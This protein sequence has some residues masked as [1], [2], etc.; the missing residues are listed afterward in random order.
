[1]MRPR[2]TTASL[3][4]RNEDLQAALRQVRS[5]RDVVLQERND[6]SRRLSE[7]EGTAAVRCVRRLWRLVDRLFPPRSHR[8]AVYLLLRWLLGLALPPF[9]GPRR[10][11]AAGRPSAG[12]GEEVQDARADLLAFEERVRDAGSDEVVVILSATKL[13]E[14]EGQRPT[15]LAVE[16]ARREVPV[17]FLYWRWWPDDWSPQD[18]LEQG[19]VQVPIDVVLDRPEALTEAFAGRRRT[20]LFA[21][22]Y[23]GFFDLVAAAHAEGWLTVYDVLDDWQEFHRVG[24]AVWYEAAFER[25][26]LCS[27]DAVFAVNQ[28]LARRIGEHGRTDPLVVG[29]GFRPGLEVVRRPRLLRRGP[30]TIGYFGHLAAAWFD[31]R[32]VVEAARR[33]PSWRFYL[34]GYGSPADL[35][36]P[37]NVG[38]LGK[39][40]QHELAA[41][42]AN[43]DV[44]IVPFKTD[45]LAAGADPIKTYEYLAIGLPVVVT[46]VSAPS[47][48]ERFVTRADGIDGFVAALEHAAIDPDRDA[49]A[50]RAFAASCTWGHRL[51]AMLAAV[52]RGDQRAAEKRALFG[53]LR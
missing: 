48:G 12:G 44:A 23:P 38:L 7:L 20:I 28:V 1:M 3:R 13:L 31:W 2:P 22:P 32:L 10:D 9:R 39:Q 5:Q 8:R 41:Y 21:F 46:G 16:W 11:A 17:V 43:W 53:G 50:R 6:L 36:L 51:D 4:E 30:V 49:A 27:C 33:R 37:E 14:S 52:T 34:I 18:R 19:I 35:E 25:H 45:R 47:G 42:A 29:N 24:Q 15:Q 40:A 26:L